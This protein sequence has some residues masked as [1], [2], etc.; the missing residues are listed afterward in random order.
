MI[1]DVRSWADLSATDGN[2]CSARGQRWGPVPGLVHG[3][4]GARPP[5]VSEIVVND[6]SEGSVRSRQI[7]CPQ[8]VESR[9][10]PMAA[11]G[12]KLQAA[13]LVGVA[14]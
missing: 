4:H 5:V 10:S 2:V 12:G 9:R 7:W 11:M 3:E 8:W 6:R 1:H 14:H 13:G